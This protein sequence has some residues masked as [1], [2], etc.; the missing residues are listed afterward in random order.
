ME[1]GRGW[2]YGGGREYSMEED[3]SM[4]GYGNVWKGVEYLGVRREEGEYWS[5]EGFFEMSS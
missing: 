3:G 5:Q 1:H 4:G 2:E